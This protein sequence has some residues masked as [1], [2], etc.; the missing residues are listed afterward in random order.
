[1]A[2]GD[3]RKTESAASSLDEWA[4]D[5]GASARMQKARCVPVVGIVMLG[6][7]LFLLGCGEADC[8]ENCSQCKDS[9]SCQHCV[10]GFTLD[11][12]TGTCQFQCTSNLKLT[13][14]ENQK[15]GLAVDD[16]TFHSCPSLLPAMWP[17]SQAKVT[18]LRLFK[19][20]QA[21]W[22]DEQR[23]VAWQSIVNFARANDA[24]VL[25]GTPLSCNE[26]DDDNDWHL[27]KELLK[28]L[29][30]KHVMGIA[31]GNEME[32]YHTKKSLQTPQGRECIQKMWPGDN[33]SSDDNGY[34]IT[35][36]M[37]RVDD[38]DALPG[39]QD[40]R[41]PV[42]SV[43]GA[44][45]LTGEIFLEIPEAKIQAVLTSLVGKYLER[46]VFTLNIYPYFDPALALDPGTK[47]QCNNAISACT[48]FKNSECIFPATAVGMR[49]RMKA[50]AKSLQLD[51]N[52]SKLWI[53]ET[54]WSYPK[55]GSLNT[56]M[57][58]CSDFSS[59][60]TARSYYENFLDWDL[61]L[62][63]QSELYPN[64]D[65][66][67]YFTVRDSINFDVREGFGLL[68]QCWANPNATSQLKPNMKCKFQSTSF[69]EIAI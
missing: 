2:N 26:T 38:L 54:G 34:F 15:K 52:K 69:P 57:V 49:S 62:P 32:L 11:E 53:T 20:W 25:V 3:F 28:L 40:S 29:T 19:A 7:C 9:H 18:S 14:N 13:V 27:V 24:K 39:F 8:K 12:T 6:S 10:E 43:F 56:P 35:K 22:S 51:L 64:V 63:S 60:H 55:A 21:D 47:D 30:P 66:V 1:M 58:S 23:Q 45:I 67:F 41:I 46:Y 68:S 65:H 36:F 4:V 44:A 48:C 50:F 37:Q 59:E 33:Q 42:T 61:S 17:N 5:S 31:I 16:T